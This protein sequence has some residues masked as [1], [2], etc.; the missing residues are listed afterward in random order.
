MCYA[1]GPRCY[2]DAKK[3]Y[4]KAQ[5]K[6]TNF[7]NEYGSEETIYALGFGV[8]RE[9]RALKKD[10]TDK[11]VD[12]QQT[13]E[14]VS[15]LSE[16]LDSGAVSGHLEESV[17][18]TMH[19]SKAGYDAQLLAHDQRNNT[20]L[21]R[22]PSKFGTTEGV[23][24]LAKKVEQAQ[25]KSE[26]EQSSALKAYEHAVAT[27]ERILNGDIELSSDYEPWEKPNKPDTIPA[28]D[29]PTALDEA[30]RNHRLAI[31]GLQHM[32]RDNAK[33]PF[34]VRHR[35]NL[36][37]QEAKIADTSEKVQQIRS[38]L[39]ATSKTQDFGTHQEAYQIYTNNNNRL[40]DLQ[41]R[42]RHVEQ[43]PQGSELGTLLAK[44]KQLEDQQKDVITFLNSE[45]TTK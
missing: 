35:T 29:L 5:E 21:G 12:L 9:Y 39:N 31:K 22:Q 3:D 44:K 42:I 7:K 27:R 19:E 15:E 32:M 37:I 8:L 28:G 14:F 40:A 2:A 23:Q 16:A 20:V 25:T 26:K 36:A 11:R 1:G 34:T 13:K 33:N 43:N 6:L 30:K 17:I 4:D 41:A 18:A 10:V 45:I 24:Y 38:A